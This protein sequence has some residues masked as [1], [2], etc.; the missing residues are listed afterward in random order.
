MWNIVF[1]LDN[2]HNFSSNILHISH[3][4]IRPSP[5]VASLISSSVSDCLLI[6]SN[7]FNSSHGSQIHNLLQAQNMWWFGSGWIPDAH[8]SRSITLLLS[9]TEKRKY[10]ESLVNQEKERR[11]HSPIPVKGKTDATWGKLFI[12]NK[13]RIGQW[14]IKSKLTATFPL[15][16]LIYSASSPLH[17]HKGTV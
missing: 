7:Y 12:T 1:H 16:V 4:S 3:F 14:E 2:L 17:Q 6:I 10:S 11:E 13:I 15:P 5:S 8:Q 9:W